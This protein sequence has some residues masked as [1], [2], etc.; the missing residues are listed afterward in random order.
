MTFVNET[1]SEGDRVKFNSF[2]LKNHIIRVG[3]EKIAIPVFVREV[4][5]WR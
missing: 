5:S 1:I 2:K 3:F 4:K